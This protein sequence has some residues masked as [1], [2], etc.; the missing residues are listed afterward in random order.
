MLLCLRRNKPISRFKNIFLW[1]LSIILKI[2][3]KLGEY[4]TPK[5]QF[6]PFLNTGSI[7][8]K[9][10]YIYIHFVNNVP[11]NPETLFYLLKKGSNFLFQS[12]D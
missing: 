10:I 12:E 2:S 3:E 1:E 8:H 5:W 7:F 9:D 11:V 6:K 4:I